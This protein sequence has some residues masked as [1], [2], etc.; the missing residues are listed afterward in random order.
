MLLMAD[1]TNSVGLMVWLISL[2]LCCLDLV[3][4]IECHVGTEA[5]KDR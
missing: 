2:R 1:D 3:G 4:C 5:T